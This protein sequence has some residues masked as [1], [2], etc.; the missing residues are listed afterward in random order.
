LESVAEGN[1]DV[2]KAA[3]E[4]VGMSEM[5]LVNEFFS[6]S[7]VAESEDDE[8]GDIDTYVASASCGIIGKVK[9]SLRTK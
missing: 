1:S 3:R 4:Q 8:F 2:A 5:D 6:E 7:E 9:I